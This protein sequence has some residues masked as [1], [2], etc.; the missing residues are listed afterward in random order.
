[1]G[2]S[3]VFDV[4]YAN[5]LNAACTQTQAYTIN[6]DTAIPDA[7]Q[8]LEVFVGSEDTD[9]EE[10]F[11]GLC[12]EGDD[13]I[14][15]ISGTGKIAELFNQ[16]ALLQAGG[17]I[18][19]VSVAGIAYDGTPQNMVS[20]ANVIKDLMLE[21]GTIISELNG[22]SIDIL[23]VFANALNLVC[24]EEVTFTITF[25]TTIPD[26][27]LT[28]TCPG[29]SGVITV[30]NDLG[31]CGA[32]VDFEATVEGVPTPITVIYKIGETVISSGHLFPEG[33]TTVDVTATNDCK[34]VECSFDVTVID[35]EPPTITCPTVDLIYDR[36]ESCHWEG[37]GLEASIDDNCGTPVLS[38]SVDDGDTW[39]LGD[40][41]DYLFPVGATDVIYKVVDGSNNEFTC[42][43]TINVRKITFSGNVSYYKGES[44]GPAM[45]NV[46]VSLTKGSTTYTTTSLGNGNFAFTEDICLGEWEVS[47]STNKGVGGVNSGDAAMVNYWSLASD[48]YDIE[49]VRFLAGD[50]NGNNLMQTADAGRIQQYF[51]NSYNLPPAGWPRGNYSFWKTEDVIDD[52]P[53]IPVPTDFDKLTLSVAEG[54]SGLVQNYYSLVTGDFNMSFT[55]SSGKS[56]EQSLSIIYADPVEVITGDEFK[57][58]LAAGFDMEIGAISL[59]MDIPSSNLQVVSAYLGDDPNMPV[60]FKIKGNELRISWYSMIPMEVSKNETVITLQ[61]KAIAD[62]D[63]DIFITL[64][65]DPVVELADGNYNVIKDGVLSIAVVSSNTAVGVN[66]VNQSDD[67][68]LANYPN[69]F[70]G[71][72]QFAYTLPADGKVTLEINDITGNKVKL[73][74]NEGQHV[75]E[76]MFTMDASALPPGMYVAILTF[77]GNDQVLKRTIKIISR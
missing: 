28:V 17:E 30:N 25:D 16:I 18:A 67:L 24:E 29:V 49:K 33:T 44:A 35:N 53:E 68:Q 42:E 71:T 26:N 6:Y 2:E 32:Q 43:F 15:D 27:P 58:P 65:N 40:A 72:T 21:H 60:I 36:N 69:P 59:I 55:P 41:N 62:A 7:Q 50:A 76:H 23:V 19:V 1:D 63:E 8:A 54:A 57:L 70:K 9:L 51:V 14:A 12:L 37:T 31:V 4:V 39:T 10:D 73:L 45:D 13:L 20:I 66:E 75:G 48:P 64:A 46:T 22:N 34:S 77:T 74:I 56:Q 38:F 52:N 11:A 3:I 47:F 61:L 5:L